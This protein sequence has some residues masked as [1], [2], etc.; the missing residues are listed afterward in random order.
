MSEER[1]FDETFKEKTIPVEERSERK[2]A[3]FFCQD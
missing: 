3:H 2:S 1:D